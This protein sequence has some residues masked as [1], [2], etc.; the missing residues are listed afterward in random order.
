MMSEAWQRA[1]N[2]LCIRLDYLGDVLMCT[3]AMRALRNAVP[4]R[5][6]TLMTSGSGAAAAPYIPELDDAI[7]Y[8]APWMKS[9]A[10]HDPA[11]DLRMAADLRARG[12]D[13]A[14][15]FTTF[16][17]SALPAAMLCYLAGIP[18]R[19]AH[20]RENPYQLMTDWV[21]DAE[22]E[23][24]IRHEVRRQRDLVAA[25]GCRTGNERLSF[26][27]PPADR[28]WISQ[29]L[30]EAGIAP[31]R[32]W[33]ML[34][35]GATAASRRYR[36]ALWA[37]AAA[38]LIERTGCALVIS[39]SADESALAEDI[40]QR[41][42]QRIPDARICSLAGELDLGKLAAAIAAAGVF[43]S[44]NTGPAHLAAAV[45]TPIVDVY[46]LT[47]PQHTPWQVP[48][49]VLYHAVPCRNC[50]RSICPQG[51]H[52]CLENL[53]PSRVTDAAVE[54]L[55]MRAGSLPD[56][57]RIAPAP[58]A[59]RDAHPVRAWVAAGENAGAGKTC[60]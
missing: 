30:Q 56:T 3:P 6:L 59:R 18:L 26:S 7:V 29:R 54:L 58:S 45:G 52:A 38:G 55:R 48:S 17:Q 57:L 49:R 44:N 60:A 23:R 20:C 24:G 33:A 10:E 2:I 5:R 32:S 50:Y 53:A 12:F 21:P 51:H 16:S 11:E 4:G 31:G 28:R 46:A 37:E 47:N 13:A 22:L 27:V 8:A 35:P 41:I 40:R 43:L 15:I 34:H 9:S 25:I 14:V 42:A 36:P 19:L 39:G 1:C